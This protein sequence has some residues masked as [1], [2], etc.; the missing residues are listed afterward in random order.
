MPVRKLIEELQQL[1]K[2]SSEKSAPLTEE[3]SGE[4][5]NPDVFFINCIDPCTDANLVFDAAPGQ[6]FVRS[7]VAAFIPPY[8]EKN[9]SELGA[10]LSYAINTG[11][12]KH[13]I[14][15]GHSHCDALAALINGE[16][17]GHYLDSWVKMAS[18]A[19]KTA[20]NKTSVKN[21][22]IALQRETERQVVIMSLKNLMEYPMVKKALQGKDPLT[23]NGWFFDMENGALHEYEPA[24]KAFK[25]L[26]LSTP[27]KYPTQK[28]PLPRPSS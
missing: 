10:S 26:D 15:M 19:K 17:S 4:G 5:T 8:D 20:G 9:P 18:R 23:V 11:K 24:A 16:T 14:I 13:L 28:P 1:Q 22:T 27:Q 3:L 2:K 6:Q 25:P 21:K 12:I 7:Q